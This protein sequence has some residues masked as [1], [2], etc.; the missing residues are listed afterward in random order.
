MEVIR[1][2]PTAIDTV[3]IGN[4][5]RK[6][7]EKLEDVAL[8]GLANIIVAGNPIYGLRNFPG[9]NTDVHGFTLN[10]ATGANWLAALSKALVK[11]VG[12]NAYAKVTIFLN[13][14]DWLYASINEFVAGYPKT[15]LQRLQEV[16]QVQEIVPAARVPANEII[17]VAGL[18]NGNWGTILS[19]M[20]LTTR[21]KARLNPE[22]DY[23]IGVIAMA[24]PQ[25]QTDY[26][27]NSPLVHVTQS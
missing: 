11:L 16:A 2:G 6:V 5:Q 20:P 1:K 12:D 22:D 14:G 9:R 18:S 13:Y 27:G 24:A 10:G 8:N 23:S 15:I 7:A 25:F 17:G 3:T 21:P 19:A 4:H 26:N